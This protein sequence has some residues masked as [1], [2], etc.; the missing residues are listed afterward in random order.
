M[1]APKRLS[2]DPAQLPAVLEALE[3][4]LVDGQWIQLQAPKGASSE[5]PAS[6]A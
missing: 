5:Q 6:S 2:V 4:A 3:Q 1:T